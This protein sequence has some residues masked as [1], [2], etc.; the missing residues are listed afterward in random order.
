MRATEAARGHGGRTPCAFG[1]PWS[2]ADLLS[3]ALKVRAATMKAAEHSVELEDED[4]EDLIV[5]DH[6]KKDKPSAGPAAVASRGFAAGSGSTTEPVR[7]APRPSPSDSVLA[8]NT[9]H[10]QL[11][12]H[13]SGSSSRDKK[14]TDLSNTATMGSGN[15]GELA[16][17]GSKDVPRSR[18]KTSEE[19]KTPGEEGAR[20]DATQD[21]LRVSPS[22]AQRSDSSKWNTVTAGWTHELIG[23]D[24]LSPV[25]KDGSRHS[26]STRGFALVPSESKSKSVDTDR[27]TDGALTSDGSGDGAHSR[28][29]MQAFGDACGGYVQDHA[30][31]T[32]QGEQDGFVRVVATPEGKRRGLVNKKLDPGAKV[33]V[34]NVR[35]V[36]ADDHPRDA[37]RDHDRQPPSDA[38][39]D[40][41]HAG[42]ADARLG[43]PSQDRSSL[44][45]Q[46]V[47][48]NEW[49][50]ANSQMGQI[51]FFSYFFIV[52][53]F[54]NFR[55]PKTGR[56]STKFLC[57]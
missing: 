57:K 28:D 49:P 6:K 48:P 2:S 32:T 23:S 8:A 54:A 39:R 5:H 35:R 46:Y 41:L 52:L 37:P 40:L 1:A 15:R 19:A 12:K 38:A 13:P 7:L 26:A 22:T 45:D 14:D 44:F 42:P 17:T 55:A 16:G 3:G 25:S 29:L 51:H 27:R 34:E 9:G 11:E 4:D 31:D 43:S 21:S 24:S 33:H 18:D 36:A 20:A 47:S 56:S 10:G 50:Q 53:N 30:N